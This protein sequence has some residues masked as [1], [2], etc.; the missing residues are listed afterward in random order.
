[1]RL[2]IIEDE[3]K[4]AQTLKGGL[5]KSGYVVDCISDGE[6]AKKHIL[7]NHEKYDLL[8][9]D[10]VLPSVDGLQI[11][12]DIR[13]LK[14]QI[15]ILMLTAHFEIKDK[16]LALNNGVD[17]FLVKPFS[18]EELEARIR[19]ILRRPLQ[20]AHDVLEFENLKIDLSN[21][22]ILLNNKSVN[23]TPKEFAILEYLLRNPN[24]VVTRN[25]IMDHVWN[26]DFDGFSN[27]VDA[28]MKNLKKKIRNKRNLLIET[29]RGVGYK[30][31]NF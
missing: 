25:E 4:L 6:V 3:K 17:D 18:F 19:A 8:I 9:L 15:P 20:T 26:S 28:H 23:L 31:R 22:K 27:I 13:K 29:V 24:R 7:I 12:K 10:W 11:C 30:L 1:M 14:I 16:V 21:H 5:E 2:L